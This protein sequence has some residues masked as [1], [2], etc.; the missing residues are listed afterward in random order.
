V[1]NGAVAQPRRR[2]ARKT[3]AEDGDPGAE[4]GLALAAEGDDPSPRK[5]RRR[6]KAESAELA[7]EP[8]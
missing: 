2:R 4:P 1:A 5:P 8:V 3:A 7:E 6:K